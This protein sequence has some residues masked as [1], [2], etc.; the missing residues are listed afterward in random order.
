MM[1]PEGERYRGSAQ[2]KAPRAAGVPS[3]YG[4]RSTLA[5]RGGNPPRPPQPG[6]LAPAKLRNGRVA[7]AD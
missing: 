7:A 5:A 6:I 1:Q 4:N 3:A 2:L